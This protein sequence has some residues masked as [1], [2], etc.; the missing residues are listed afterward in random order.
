MKKLLILYVSFSIL[1]MSSI[2]AQTAA[3]IDISVDALSVKPGGNITF[4]VMTYGQADN[5][6]QKDASVKI[7][8]PLGDMFYEKLIRT[9]ENTI[10]VIEKNFTSGYWTIEAASEDLRT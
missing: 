2:Y 7:I 5:F 4:R 8:N 10:F 1:L 6:V 3:K 9:G